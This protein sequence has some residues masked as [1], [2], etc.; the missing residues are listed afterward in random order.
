MDNE[1]QAIYL[2]PKAEYD[3]RDGLKKGE[4]PTQE[5]NPQNVP[6]GKRTPMV[7]WKR[8]PWGEGQF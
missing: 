2:A 6:T 5:G 8:L 3:R 1:K 7:K 4:N